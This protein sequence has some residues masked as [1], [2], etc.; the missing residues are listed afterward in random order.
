MIEGFSQELS[1]HDVRR[2]LLRGRE[3]KVNVRVAAL[4]TV[5]IRAEASRY[6]FV[7]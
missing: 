2:G 4:A 3:G 7:G 6:L 5:P 1:A